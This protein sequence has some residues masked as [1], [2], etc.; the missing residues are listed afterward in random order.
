MLTPSRSRTARRYESVATNRRPPADAASNTPVRIGRA[1]SRDAAGTTWRSASVSAPAATFTPAPPG[2]VN[3]GK[4]AADNVRNDVRNRPAST[5]AS[6]SV[7]STDT[8]PGSSL[9]TISENNRA[10]TTALPSPS[11]SAGASTRI[12]SSRS[13]PTSSTP[14]AVGDTRKPDKTGRAPV[15]EAT[16]RCA[17]AMASARVSRS[18]RN[19]TGYLLQS[20]P[21]VSSTVGDL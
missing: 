13:D 10:G 11:V 21:S 18:Q 12:V 1:S 4:S 15:R 6:S 5:R 9:C 8:V 7:N 16:A 20:V 3:R 2:S 19:F 17:I 14:D